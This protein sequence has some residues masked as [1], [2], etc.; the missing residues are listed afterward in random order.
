MQYCIHCGHTKSYMIYKQSK[1]LFETCIYSCSEI[2][3]GISFFN[4]LFFSCMVNMYIYFLSGNLFLKVFFILFVCFFL[5]ILN[6][7]MIT[8]GFN[9]FFIEACAD[10]EIFFQG[11][12][13]RSDGYLSYHLKK[14]E[15]AG[16][17]SPPPPHLQIR[18]C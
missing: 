3:T 15:F 5:H 17:S 2:Y 8:F 7:R 10:S 1:S 13:G 9:L 14:F 11:G 6:K 12:G 16:G 18:I 4:I